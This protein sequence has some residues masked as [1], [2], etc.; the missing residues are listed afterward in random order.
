MTAFEMRKKRLADITEQAKKAFAH[1]ELV[2][3]GDR[4]WLIGRRYEDNNKLNSAYLTSIFC[5]HFGQ[6]YVGGDVDVMVFGCYGDS[7]DLHKRLRWM[8]RCKDLGYYIAQKAQIG[9]T[10]NKKL[11]HDRDVDI[12][13]VEIRE[14]I[15]MRKND[16]DGEW[17]NG[18][19]DEDE[20]DAL[21]RA[22]EQLKAGEPIQLV[23]YELFSEVGYDV[24][25]S[26]APLGEVL[27]SR[28]IYTWQAIARLCDLLDDVQDSTQTEQAPD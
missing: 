3:H 27:S 16:S 21:I 14:F 5:D 25:E 22:I 2:D 24:L 10:D 23:E 26:L 17:P 19:E 18:R 11:T 4:W 15:E 20:R 1:H 13:V 12:A 7:R 9:M 6:I 28:V 8:G